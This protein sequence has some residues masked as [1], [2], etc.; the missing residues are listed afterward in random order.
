MRYRKAD[1]STLDS[2]ALKQTECDITRLLVALYNGN[3]NNIYIRIAYEVSV[4]SDLYI[5]YDLRSNYAA[6]HDLNDVHLV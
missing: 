2:V 6:R 1:S 4:L 3:L 5:L